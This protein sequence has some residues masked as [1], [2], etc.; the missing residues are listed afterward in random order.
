MAESVRV[1]NIAEVI[2][3]LKKKGYDAQAV[4]LAG[5]RDVA[6]AMQTEVRR[7]LML[8][9]NNSNGAH[10]G[11]S[12]DFPNRRTGTLARSIEIKPS[13]SG[14]GKYK[15]EVGPTVVYSRILE[16]GFENGNR[17]PYMEPSVE[18]LRPRIDTIFLNAVKRYWRG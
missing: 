16:L 17:Y 11:S 3:A 8:V 2:A 15:F 5:G 12:G 13:V 6:L 7:N 18:K 1:D 14:L 4:A 10:I 9:Q